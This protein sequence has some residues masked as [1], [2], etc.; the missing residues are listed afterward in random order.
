LRSCHVNE[1]CPANICCIHKVFNSITFNEWLPNCQIRIRIIQILFSKVQWCDI[2]NSSQ[3]QTKLRGRNHKK[4]INRRYMYF[5]IQII[6]KCVF[7][8]HENSNNTL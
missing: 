1:G 3:H 5:V 8:Y 7:D 4:Q 2:R 6:Y